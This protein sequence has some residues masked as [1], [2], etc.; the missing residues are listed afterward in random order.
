MEVTRTQYPVG[1]G[2][3][4]AGRIE[5]RYPDS[6]SS[7]D[8]HY[9]Y[10]CG[11]S[12]GS[13]ALQDAVVEWRSQVPRI[14]ALFV[15]HLDIDHV[16][17]ID[18]LLASVTVDT[19]YIPYVDAATHV[20]DIL[21]AD[22]EGALSASLI[23]ARLDPGSWFGRRGVARIVRVRAARDEGPADPESESFDD[24][25]PGETAPPSVG[26]P[27]K[28]PFEAKARS[29]LF[30]GFI[31]Q[32]DYVTMDS[33]MMVVV[34][35]GQRLLWVLVPHV[36]PATNAKRHS[37]YR[38]VRQV[39]GLPPR[40][41]LKADR[42]ATALRD[43]G[44][45]RRLRQCYEQI[46][47]GGS[48]RRHNRMSMSLYSGP[49][50][51]GEGVRWWRYVALAQ[52]EHWPVWR[53][54][55]VPPDYLSSEQAAV[56]WV[57]TGDA[58]LNLPKIRAAWKRSFNPFSDYIATLLL[59]HH[60]SR[61]SFDASLLDWPCLTLCVAS[62]GDP[63]QYGHPHRRVIHEVVRRAKV[64]HHVSQRPQTQLREVLRSS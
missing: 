30:P 7:D 45:R 41:R 28:A 21:E 9:V 13:A 31:G 47:S 63:S 22:T 57:G 32:P 49:A 37:F 16:N 1:Q 52:S 40:R 10:D 8:F 5:W 51:S 60:G 56:G 29:R 61:L 38:E 39:L 6:G 26:L 58:S 17:G 42:L 54:H 3:F 18:R 23:E 11:S 35:P 2:C 19:V 43:V 12:D 50:P 4:H 44:E 14:D 46:I 27:P 24:D 59:P 34:N 25:A 33:G 48:G 55:A 53:L 64:M 15:S 62:A 36:D 20:F